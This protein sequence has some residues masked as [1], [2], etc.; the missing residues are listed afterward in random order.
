MLVAGF[1]LPGKPAEANHLHLSVGD[2]AHLAMSLQITRGPL[3]MV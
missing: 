2:Q 1:L 3:R